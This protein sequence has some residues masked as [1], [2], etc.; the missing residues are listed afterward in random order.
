MSEK[1]YIVVTGGVVSGIGKGIT[2]ATVGLILKSSGLS[3]DVIKFDPYLNID[4]GTMSP[5][6]HGEVYVLDDGSET[7][8]DL[9]HYE[10]FLETNLT[11]ISSVTAGKVY[12]TILEQEREGM[13]LGK[14]VQLIPNVTNYIKTC[15]SKDFE[16]DIRLIEIGGSTGDMEGD[17]FLESFRQFRLENPANVFHIHLGYIPYL[18]C[19]GEY[20]S[21]PM[22]SSL[23]EL[24]RSG[25][26]PDMVILRS[27]ATNT[28][29][30]DQSIIDKI[31]LFSNLTPDSV[32][33]LPDMGSI[34][35]V[36]MYVL[37]TTLLGNLEVFFGRSF[38]SKLPDFYD[39][40][41]PVSVL[42]DE[43]IIGLVTKYT[44]LADAYLSVFESCKIA[45]VEQGLR[46]KV[47]MI[48]SD[49]ETLE[50]DIDSVQGIIVPGGFGKRGMEG[51]IKA[52]KYIR[53]NNIP[54]LGICLGL[55]MAVVEYARNVCGLDVYSSEMFD[56][57]EEKAGKQCIVDFIPG[58]EN[59]KKKGGTM[60][61]GSY[62]CYIQGNNTQSTLAYRLYEV[63][64]TLERHRHRLE[65]QNAFVPILELNGMK[66]TGK[67]YFESP[68]G[69]DKYL[70]EIVELDTSVHPYFIAIQ[71]HPE[72]LSRPSKAHPLFKG[73]VEAATQRVG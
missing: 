44:K 12:N 32:I 59:I 68:V 11:G 4:P 24:L 37:K 65:V 51:K 43:I 63:N 67:Y 46:V 2:A 17:I 10:R 21:K 70:V 38:V 73:L 7:D 66:I 71:S 13:F 8:L 42:K 45:G 30:L 56:N 36:P 20:K 49:S 54:F 34:Y 26:Q 41:K 57:E 69:N 48:D 31:A 72:F 16:S 52:I 15:F 25:L 33:S 64:E 40:Y 61:L 53:E 29:P 39:K 22:Q 27:E 62:K 60:R 35:E 55:Q 47:V 18:A 6:E 28:R 58:Q 19:S 23:R 1:K 50:K 3:I 5:F 9:G 14:N